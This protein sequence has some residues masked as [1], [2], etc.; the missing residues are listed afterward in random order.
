MV[1][2]AAVAGPPAGFDPWA[3]VPVFPSGCY[4]SKDDFVEKLAGAKE[5]VTKEFDRQEKINDDLLNRFKA[6]GPAE[7]QTR[8][9]SFMMENPEEGMKL[10]QQNQAVGDKYTEAQL[11]AE[12]NRQKL[13]GE[14]DDLKARWSA[15]LAKARAPVDARFKE[16]DARAQKDLVAIGESRT[17]APW[18]VK[19]Y[20]ALVLQWNAE[21]QKVCGEWWTASGPFQSW[22]KRYKEN[23]VQNQ[24]PTLEAEDN[25]GAGFMVHLLDTPEASFKST[26]TVRAVR[27]YIQRV[28]EVFG[29]R[30]SNPK[31]PFRVGL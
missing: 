6:L 11:K 8:L 17:Y 23:V 31:P 14:L 21:T 27:E 26:A 28:S 2:T 10:M 5:A 30:E 25:A 13:V 22:L 1:A 19:E 9:Q 29:V 7:I 12:A 4:S 24:I 18:A 3:K 16:L 20:D 15:S